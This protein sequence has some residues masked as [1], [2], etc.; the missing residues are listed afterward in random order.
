[1][2]RFFILFVLF[3]YA[4]PSRAG[5]IR[6]AQMRVAQLS[7]QTVQVTINLYT[8]IHAPAPTLE[9]CWGD[10]QCEDWASTAGEEWPL[11]ATR[12]YQ[13]VAFHG[14]TQN[15]TVTIEASTCCWAEEIL[16]FSASPDIPVVLSTDFT[17]NVGSPNA[18]N[19]TPE[20]EPFFSICPVDVCGYLPQVEETEGDRLHWSLCDPGLVGYSPLEDL[21]GGAS[22]VS[23]DAQSGALSWVG[24][25]FEGLYS[26]VACVAEIRNG[27][28]I[29][30][31]QVFALLVVNT[32]L[33]AKPPSIAEEIAIVPNPVSDLLQVQ[34]Q[35]ISEKNLQLRIYDSMGQKRWEQ[36]GVQAI[37]LSTWPAGCYFLEVESEGSKVVKRFL[38]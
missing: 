27:D 20:V 16:N 4:Y 21:P 37:E 33:P 28:T 23:L 10:G 25:S 11:L 7:Q 36:S 18:F 9:L 30:R 24:P 38:R 3:C 12:Q 17:L 6:A 15:G 13:L 34:V 29:S 8:E 31:S 35:N 1:M 5:S 2:L 22:S 14:Y 26:H 32:A 19:S